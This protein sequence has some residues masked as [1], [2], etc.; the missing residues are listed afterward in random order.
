MIIKVNHNII[1]VFLV[2]SMKLCFIL[3]NRISYIDEIALK[4][5]SSRSLKTIA[6]VSNME[7]K[8][9]FQ[10]IIC[11]NLLAYILIGL[12]IFFLLL[13]YWNVLFLKI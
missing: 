2:D 12:A 5:L 6:G 13:T 3:I 4:V 11:S 7:L 8:P 10:R 9:L 1:L